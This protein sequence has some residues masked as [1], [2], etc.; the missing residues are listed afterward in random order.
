MAA[1]LNLI[2]WILRGK[3]LISLL[4]VHWAI[5][6]S[7][8]AILYHG[9]HYA[10]SKWVTKRTYRTANPVPGLRPMKINVVIPVEC[11]GQNDSKTLRELQMT[12][13]NLETEAT[14]LQARSDHPVELVCIPYSTKREENIPENSSSGEHYASVAASISSSGTR[15]PTRLLP[16]EQSL[17]AALNKGASVTSSDVIMFLL[18][19][20]TLPT[21]Y[22]VLINTAAKKAS[23]SCRRIRTQSVY[24]LHGTS[25]PRSPGEDPLVELCSTFIEKCA[26]SDEHMVETPWAIP[27]FEFL[28]VCCPHLHKK[29]SFGS[30]DYQHC[31]CRKL[32][33]RLV[34]EESH[35]ALVEQVD[36]VETKGRYLPH[37]LHFL[38]LKLARSLLA[39][40]KESMKLLR[41]RSQYV[42]TVTSLSFDTKR[43]GIN[44][45]GSTHSNKVHNKKTDPE[46]PSLKFFS[47]KRAPRRAQS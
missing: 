21:G 27:L 30:L 4:K 29:E 41:L 17:D 16:L 3:A 14:C 25:D 28:S 26:V 38:F 22:D 39:A 19:G 33:Q 8:C 45:N 13:K 34:A 23:R 24:K 12:V 44:T 46:L 47:K 9:V 20:T 31:A 5:I 32:R 36:T 37:W 7:V 15:L 10:I 42:T 35:F 43:D 18:P 1:I 40:A 11:G 6:C 2:L